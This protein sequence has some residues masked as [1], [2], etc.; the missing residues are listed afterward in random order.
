MNQLKVNQQ[1]TILTLIKQGW[2]KRRIALE[3]GLDRATV[4]KYAGSSKPATNPN[5]GSDSKSPNP[6][7]GSAGPESSCQ[8][9]TQRIQQAWSSGLSIQRIF[10]K[11]VGPEK[12]RSDKRRIRIVRSPHKRD[13]FHQREQRGVAGARLVKSDHDFGGGK[14]VIGIRRRLVFARSAV[15]SYGPAAALAEWRSAMN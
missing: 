2:S 3:L 8:P 4:R 15:V 7:T 12:G 10:Q 14:G 11:R 1:Q 5:T 6:I 9:W 13:L